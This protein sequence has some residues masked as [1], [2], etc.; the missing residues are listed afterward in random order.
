MRTDVHVLP[1][2]VQELNDRD[3]LPW[4]R[5]EM[6]EHFPGLGPQLHL[7]PAA[8]QAPMPDVE[9]E[10]TKAENLASIRHWPAADTVPNPLANQR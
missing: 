9:L 3:H 4:A 6:T 8:Q 5:C 10:V 1:A 2:A 7:L